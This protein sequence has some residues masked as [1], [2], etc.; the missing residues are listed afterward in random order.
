MAVSAWLALASGIFLLIGAVSLIGLHF[1]APDFNPVRDAVSL[2]VYA[3]FGVLY[4]VQAVTTGL[5]ALGLLA[6]LLAQEDSLPL[7]GLVLF[8]VYG[9]S[10]VLTALFISDPKP[11][12]TRR[13]MVHVLLATIIF[14]AIAFATGLLTGSLEALP[15]WRGLGALL[16]IAAA[17]TIGSVALTFAISTQARLRPLIG[18]AERGI[19]VGAFAWMAC[20]LAPLLV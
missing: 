18:V 13:G 16:V 3:R 20:V 15:R 4:R 17:L 6:A 1:G 9:V 10:R 8:G 11:P 19:Y 12:L 5:G 2:Y 14:T 7:I